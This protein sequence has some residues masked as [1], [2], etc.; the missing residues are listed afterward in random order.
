MKSMSGTLQIESLLGSVKSKALIEG[1]LSRKPSQPEI[2]E[3]LLVSGRNCV[4]AMDITDG[5]VT[6]EGKTYFN[7]VG[8]IK[9]KLNILKIF[10]KRN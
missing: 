8:L 1:E 3:I 5:G 9:I 7:V 4:S 10:L 6:L 2:S